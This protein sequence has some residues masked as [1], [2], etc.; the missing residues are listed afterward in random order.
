[1][2]LC[3]PFFFT[4]KKTKGNIWSFQVKRSFCGQH[5]STK[6]LPDQLPLNK[7]YQQE[8]T[9]NLSSLSNMD[10]WTKLWGDVSAKCFNLTGGKKKQLTKK[11]KKKNLH[12]SE[13]KVAEKWEAL[14][15]TLNTQCSQHRGVGLDP[16]SPRP[17][18]V[19]RFPEGNSIR[20][21]HFC[22]QQKKKKRKKNY[23]WLAILFFFFF[24]KCTHSLNGS[25]FR[26]L[27]CQSANSL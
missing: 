18:T 7:H 1:M 3:L 27:F 19:V 2:I 22:Q 21:V 16:D 12:S 20:N 11:T 23:M 10:L 8:K 15:P 14:I 6:K 4:K 17:R 13:D 25:K 24:F 9:T 26:K 5:L